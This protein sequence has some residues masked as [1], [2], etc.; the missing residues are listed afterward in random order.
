[1]RFQ[2]NYQ[3]IF[4]WKSQAHPR[5]RT[6][7]ETRWPNLSQNNLKKGI[8]QTIKREAIEQENIFSIYKTEK[9][10]YLQYIYQNLI[11]Q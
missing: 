11:N 5:A 9:H 3:Q 4:L 7:I 8:M 1:M 2:S 10:L 6:H